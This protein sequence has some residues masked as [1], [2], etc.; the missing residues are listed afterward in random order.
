M[1]EILRSV[2]SFFKEV[3][4]GVLEVI[5]RPGK[6][7]TQTALV[8]GMLFLGLLVVA[9]LGFIIYSLIHPT[10]EREI[11]VVPIEPR[12]KLTRRE[13]WV[14][15]GIFSALTIV[16]LGLASNYTSKPSFCGQCHIVQKEYRSWQDS[17]HRKVQCLACH[18]QPGISGFLIQKMGYLRETLLYFTDGYNTPLKAFVANESCLQC[19]N[20][21]TRKVV[22]SLGIRVRHQD[23][24]EKG[25]RCTDCHNTVAHGDVVPIPRFPSMNKCVTCHDDIKVSARCNLCHKGDIGKVARKRGE[26]FVKVEVRFRRTC[27]G[28]HSTIEP[29]VTRC[30][31]VEMPHSEEWVLQGAHA[32]TAFTN[33][34]VCWRC[35]P[36]GPGDEKPWSFCN[37]CHTFPP[38]HPS[39]KEWV[40][41][42]TPAGRYQ[43]PPDIL[44][45]IETELDC[46]GCHGRATGDFCGLCHPGKGYK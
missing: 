38:P 43:I 28:C 12:P 24:L 8:I 19:H 18:Q 45:G 6:D 13:L 46:V 31:G 15:W 14:S 10:A 3:V 5:A 26:D 17:S 7:P 40:K 4:A 2:L 42:H 29:C 22:S 32:R 11:V 41:W 25:D 39:G 33:K 37:R 34:P 27:R 21:I 30:H 23:F 16:I 36:G 44:A 35:H 20:E 9:M 1:E